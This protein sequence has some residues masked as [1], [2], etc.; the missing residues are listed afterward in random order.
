MESAELLSRLKPRSR[1]GNQAKEL[2]QNSGIRPL[3]DS[4]QPQSPWEL[5][6]NA[7]A[8]LHQEPQATA[9]PE[10]GK[11]LAWFIIFY[12]SSWMLQPR[13]QTL[14]AKGEGQRS[15]CGA[16]CLKSNPSEFD[17]LTP[18]DLKVCAHLKAT[19]AAYGHT[20]YTLGE[21]RSLP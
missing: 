13:E 14:T 10:T 2:R 1:Y 18:Q 17:Y 12:S 20:D 3:V 4:L 19:Y 8:S 11:R 5:C 6:L 16:C 7:L 15:Q 21:R 9:K